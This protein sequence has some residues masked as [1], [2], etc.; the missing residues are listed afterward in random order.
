MWSKVL[1]ARTVRSYGTVESVWEFT[2]EGLHCN[3]VP[4]RSG[5]LRLTL[6][7]HIAVGGIIAEFGKVDM[8][9][10]SL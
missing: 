1:H 6:G 7:V 8:E 3:V 9:D 4:L 10:S 2:E 5:L